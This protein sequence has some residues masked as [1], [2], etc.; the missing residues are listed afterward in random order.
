MYSLSQHLASI[1][2]KN[3]HLFEH[4]NETQRKLNVVLELSCAAQHQGFLCQKPSQHSTVM[5]GGGSEE[6]MFVLLLFT[7]MHQVTLWSGAGLKP[8]MGRL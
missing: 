8:D 3:N 1:P 4:I 5:S 6:A 7:A 2:M